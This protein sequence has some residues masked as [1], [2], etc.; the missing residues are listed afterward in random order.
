MTLHSKPREPHDPTR[1]HTQIQAAIALADLVEAAGA[2][3]ACA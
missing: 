3:R 1:T 2:A